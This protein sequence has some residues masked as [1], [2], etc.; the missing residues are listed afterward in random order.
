MVKLFIEGGGD[1]NP[2]LASE[3]RQAF[4]VF[5]S[6]A[7]PHSRNPRIVACGGRDSAFKDFCTA[8]N[9]NENAML[10]VDSEDPVTALGPIEHLKTRDNWSFPD[11]VNDSRCGLMVTCMESWF[12]ADIETLSA[13]FGNDFKKN[14]FQKNSSS[15]ENMDRK[16]VLSILENA[17]KD[18]KKGQYSKGRD[19]F[20]ILMKIDP[21]KVTEKSRWAKIFLENLDTLL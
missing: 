18:T 5:L 1:H 12:F 19:S 17:S 14:N 13:Y 6:K 2:A 4:S 21:K 15:I 20:K 10:L 11:S 8:C 3:L 7:R 9:N 16:S